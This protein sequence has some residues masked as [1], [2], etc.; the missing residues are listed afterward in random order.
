LSAFV[1]ALIAEKEAPKKNNAGTVKEPAMVLITG[2]EF[3]MGKDYGK[4]K[5]SDDSVYIDNH[6]HKVFVDSFYIDKY[7][8]TNAQYYKFC[9]ETDRALPKF[10]NMDEFHSG[11]KYPNHPVVGVS[12]YEAKAYAEWRGVR[13]PTE[14]EWEYAARGGLAGKSY[15]NGDDLDTKDAN[16]SKHYKGTTEV[17][18]FKPNGYGLYDVSG[19]VREWVSDYYNKD[20]YNT[21]PY[22]NPTGPAIGKFRVV[23]GGGWFSGKGCCTIYARNAIKRSWVD[24]AVGFR[25]AK[26]AKK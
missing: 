2:G 13:L 12:C 25:C 18:R 23:R 9:K 21:G 1:F 26:D 22:K 17:G 6:A 15:P 5:K 14:A 20:Y 10:W 4:E 3:I 8:V 11:L 24:F 19:N 16:T 7:E